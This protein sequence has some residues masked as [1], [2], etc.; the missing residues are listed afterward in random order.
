MLFLQANIVLVVDKRLLRDHTDLMTTPT[1]HIIRA[2]SPAPRRLY[3]ASPCATAPTSPP[4]T[5]THMICS[6]ISRRSKRAVRSFQAM[7]T[8]R[9][10]S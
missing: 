9:W 5:I 2:K 4:F 6:G 8:A 10:G 7:N 3:P 1:I